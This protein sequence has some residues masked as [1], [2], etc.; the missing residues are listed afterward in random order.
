MVCQMCPTMHTSLFICFLVVCL[1]L[2]IIKCY[3][4]CLHL[5]TFIN[6]ATPSAANHPLKIPKHQPSVHVYPVADTP[7]YV[8][9]STSTMYVQWKCAD[10]NWNSTTAISLGINSSPA[11]I[12]NPCP[13]VHLA[14]TFLSLIAIYQH[15]HDLVNKT[16]SSNTSD[17][18]AFPLCMIV[19]FSAHSNKC[20]CNPSSV[21]DVQRPSRFAAKC[22]YVSNL[23]PVIITVALV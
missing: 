6:M 4:L 22:C 8:G 17:S 23:W 13:G 5:D 12:T 1:F 11:H 20:T 14:S 15:F 9:P 2:L 3:L 10:G 18:H 16:R 19:H 7:W 21:Q